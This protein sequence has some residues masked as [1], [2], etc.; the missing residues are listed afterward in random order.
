MGTVVLGTGSCLPKRI[1]TNKE[2]ETIV[3][4]SAEWIKTRTGIECRHIGGKGEQT[5]QLSARA[6]EKALAAAGVAP[7]EL[8]LI[9]LG[10]ISSHMLMPSSACFVQKE[11]GA[12]N[13]F[14]FDL[15][16]ACSG[17]LY[18]LDL[19]DKYIRA[20]HSMKILVIGAETLSSRLNWQDRN[21]CILFGDGAGAA[22]FAHSDTERGVIGSNLLSD[23]SLWDLLYMHAPQSLNPDLLVAGND[24]THIHMEGREVFKYAVRAMEEAVRGL[25]QKQNIDIAS[26]HFVIPHQANMRI[27]TNL[28]ERLDIPRSK[29]FINVAK[30][31]NTSA[32]S[33]PIALDEANRS[34]LLAQGDTVLLCS[35]GGG[36]TWGATLI[37]W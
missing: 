6:A 31:G 19:A 28:I 29:V 25:L 32:A 21:T 8:G 10:T 11:I 37:K 24:G 4:T 35:F 15:N 13:A 30:Y 17:F 34:G 7:E 14:A 23:G 33:I 18:G 3:D 16:A 20:D 9:V 12:T 36:F 26:I 27:L 5:Y 1:L 2:L 22:V